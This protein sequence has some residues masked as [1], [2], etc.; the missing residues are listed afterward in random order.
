MQGAEGMRPAGRSSTI[1]SG[2]LGV[3]LW[4]LGVRLRLYSTHDGAGALDAPG[5]QPRNRLEI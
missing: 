2:C 3:M 5:M 4:C 1:V